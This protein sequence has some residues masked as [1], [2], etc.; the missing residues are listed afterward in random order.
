MKEL[1]MLD[2]TLPFYDQYIH[3]IHV[4]I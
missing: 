3:V 2:G 4:R 1:P